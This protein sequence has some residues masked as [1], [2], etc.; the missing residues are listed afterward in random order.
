MISIVHI[1]SRWR[2][3]EIRCY[4]NGQLVSY[5]D[6]AWHVN[7]ND[8]ST[9]LFPPPHCCHLFS[10]LILMFIGTG[11]TEAA[12]STFHMA[13][14]CE[15]GKKKS[16]LKS[17]HWAKMSFTASTWISLRNMTDISVLIWASICHRAVLREGGRWNIKHCENRFMYRGD[18]HLC[19]GC[20]KDKI[21]CICVWAEI[22][23]T[24][25]LKHSCLKCMTP[26]RV[27]V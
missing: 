23:N 27:V 10:T 4:V 7:T 17:V 18:I 20:Q 26:L 6:M 14:K 3:S 11:V 16:I 22:V 19:I 24:L 13:G 9:F 5:G 2:N 8:V 15:R 12:T 21:Y 1:Y 25:R